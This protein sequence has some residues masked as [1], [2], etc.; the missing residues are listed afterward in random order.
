MAKWGPP[1]LKG[2]PRPPFTWEYGDP[3]SPFS[4]ENGDPFVEIGDSHLTDIKWVIRIVINIPDEEDT[5]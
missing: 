2:D 1:K 5:T 4:L 3:G